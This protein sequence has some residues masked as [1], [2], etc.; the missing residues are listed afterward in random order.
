MKKGKIIIANWG[1]KKSF[2]VFILKFLIIYFYLQIQ[3]IRYKF[4]FHSSLTNMHHAFYAKISGSARPNQNNNKGKMINQ[5]RDFTPTKHIIFDNTQYQT[6]AQQ[7]QNYFQPPGV[8]NKGFCSSCTKIV[9]NKSG[10]S[11]GKSK[12]KQQDCRKLHGG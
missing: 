11:N 12:S 4:V 7:N 5:N 3:I 2:V 8:K 9:F 1:E 10:I 6:K